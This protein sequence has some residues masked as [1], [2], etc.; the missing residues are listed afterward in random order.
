MMSCSMIHWLIGA[1]WLCSTKASLPR[2]D[3]RNRTMISPLAKSYS[4]AGAI[5]T[6]R[7]SATSAASSGKARPPNSINFFWLGAVIPLTWYRSPSS[8]TVI[9]RG[10]PPVPPDVRSTRARWQEPS[11]YRARPDRTLGG[12]VCLFTRTVPCCCLCRPCSF[13]IAQDPPVG[14]V[15]VASRYAEVPGRH[16]LADR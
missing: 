11:F 3:S 6:P 15:L 12:G 14:V 10:T 1:V 7:H 5:S 2:T 8:C 4:F 13:S 16:V 9:F